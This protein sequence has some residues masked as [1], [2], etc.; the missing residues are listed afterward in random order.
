MKK[1]MVELLTMALLIGVC[2]GT[3]VAS[4]IA[5][6]AVIRWIKWMFVFAFSLLAI[7]GQVS[8]A[9]ATLLVEYE[10]DTIASSG[11]SLSP[12]YHAA[13]NGSISAGDL[14]LTTNRYDVYGNGDF[15]GNWW[16]MGWHP[17]KNKYYQ[18][19]VNCLPGYLWEPEKITF[20]LVQYLS[21]NFLGPSYYFIYASTDGFNQSEVSIGGH[22]MHTSYNVEDKVEITDFSN[23]GGG[24]FESLTFRIHATN[25][26]NVALGVGGLANS[27]SLSGDG[28][29]L[30]IEGSIQSAVIPEPAS[31]I[32]M[33][34]GGI[35]IAGMRLKKKNV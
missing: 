33:I 6:F 31:S 27:D 19:S 25:T 3:A 26:G 5:N 35:V 28:S 34:V 1:K 15:L 16:P 10:I 29:N 32:L 20:S 8:T 2:N 11:N 23:L 14:I 24:A 17:D 18:F 22:A 30:L 9:S 13:G 7:I 12:T 4:S 21:N